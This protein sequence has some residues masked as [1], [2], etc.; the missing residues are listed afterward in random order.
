MDVMTFLFTEF[1]K[2]AEIMDYFPKKNVL[3]LKNIGIEIAVS[4][5]PMM[6][7]KR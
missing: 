6:Y 7:G 1:G 4:I 5:I 3:D 2:T